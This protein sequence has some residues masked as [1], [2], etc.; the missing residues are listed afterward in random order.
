MWWEARSWWPTNLF[1]A[2]ASCLVNWEGIFSAAN[3]M[4]QGFSPHQQIAHLGRLLFITMKLHEHHVVRGIHLWLVDFP[5]RGSVMWKAFPCHGLLSYSGLILGLRP[6]NGRHRYKVTPSLTG[7]AQT[8]NQPWY[9]CTIYYCWNHLIYLEQKSITAA[10][11][12]AFHYTLQMPVLCKDH[13]VNGLSQ[14]ETM[15]H[16]NIVFHWLSPYTEWSLLHMNRHIRFFN[17]NW[18]LIGKMFHF[19]LSECYKFSNMP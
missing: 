11:I 19:S 8:Q 1:S 10:T 9:W 3:Q 7:W 14:W 4:S 5:H 12:D 17:H 16:C 18:C 6:S 2:V 15:L 13:S